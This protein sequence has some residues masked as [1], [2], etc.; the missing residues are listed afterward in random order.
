MIRHRK[1]NII[2]K[3]LDSREDVNDSYSEFTNDNVY[4]NTDKKEHLYINDNEYSDEYD[5]QYENNKEKESV[6]NSDYDNIDTLIISC[7]ELY[8]ISVLG[9][10]DKLLIYKK[11]DFNNIKNIV[12]SSLGTVISLYLCYNYSPKNILNIIM[13]NLTLINNDI[14]NIK[15]TYGFFEID[16]FVDELLRPLIKKLGY[17]PTLYDVYKETD[18]NCVFITYNY[19]RN[20][21]VTYSYKSHKTVHVNELIKKCCVIPLVFKQN[22]KI[23]NIHIH[24]N[25]ITKVESG[26]QDLYVDYTYIDEC[27]YN[28]ASKLLN[29]D[30]SLLL[31][32]NIN[33]NLNPFEYEKCNIIDYLIILLKIMQIREKH[34]Y[35]IDNEYNIYRN[36]KII[37]IN[38][39]EQ[40]LLLDNTQKHKVFSSLFCKGYDF[41][42]EYNVNYSNDKKYSYP[43]TKNKQYEG[44]VIAGGGTNVFK[45]LGCIK[46]SLEHDII[47]LDNISVYI[48]TSAGSFA[49]TMFA[50]G[51]DI[52]TIVEVYVD[53]ISKKFDLSFDFKNILERINDKS[54]YSNTLLIE[55]YESVFIMYRDGQIPTLLDVKNKYNKELVFVV[56]NLTKNQLEYL[57]YQNAP[58]LL[59]TH[60][61]AMSSCLPVVFNPVLYNKCYYIDGGVKSNFPIEKTHDYLDKHFIG[62]GLNYMN[63]YSKMNIAEFF[64]Y[65]MMENLRKYQIIKEQISLNCTYYNVNI[66]Y[67][68]DRD[69]ETLLKVDRNKLNRY[70]DIG[71]SYMNKHIKD[72]N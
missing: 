20:K 54:L 38:T 30:T 19:S 49:S 33:H 3:K 2:I 24:Q 43:L 37:D 22:I 32:V 15:E 46:Y 12:S 40:T 41:D 65:L 72:K 42:I 25:K 31:K 45:C 55:C 44:I 39:Y 60:A 11:L 18:K 56:Y 50:L 61:C 63:N 10:I 34:N 66:V 48:G 59:V 70:I 57:N 21:V 26:N 16:N 36:Y 23:D 64:L 29:K 52:N 5:E 35:N 47:N 4:D 9:F 14:I 68:D 1:R 28:Y 13:D 8:N 7:S 6:K 67:D 27:E 53:T 51:F 58:D 62:F 17:V 69:G 71:Y